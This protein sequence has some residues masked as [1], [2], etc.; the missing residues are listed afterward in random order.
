MSRLAE[1]DPRPSRWSLWLPLA[2]KILLLTSVLY[3]LLG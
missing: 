3:C 1:I 2:T